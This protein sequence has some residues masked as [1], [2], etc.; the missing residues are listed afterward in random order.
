MD[1]PVSVDKVVASAARAGVLVREVNP[2]RPV[3]VHSVPNDLNKPSYQNQVLPA[4]SYY[5]CDAAVLLY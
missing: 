2:A 1:N 3:D 5:L 4:A